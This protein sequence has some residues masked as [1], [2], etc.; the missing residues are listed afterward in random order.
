VKEGDGEGW[1]TH[2]D[3]TAPRH[4]TYWRADALRDVVAGA[5]WVDVVVTDGLAGKRQETWLE[6]TAVNP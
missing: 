5:G 4:F 3:V 2:G 6:V 1:S